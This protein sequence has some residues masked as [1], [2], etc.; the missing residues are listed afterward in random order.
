M[1]NFGLIFIYDNVSIRSINISITLAIIEFQ[2]PV[3]KP[4][5]IPHLIFLLLDSLSACATASRID[6]R[7]VLLVSEVL[8]FSSSKYTSTSRLRNLFITSSMST[9]LRPNR[10]T[11]LVII[12]SIL[13]RLWCEL[14]I[15][16]IRWCKT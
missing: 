11:D 8:M 16:N 13:F 3:S 7:K 2:F 14:K 1:Y 12:K 15:I 9:V 5:R 4:R 10:L 6:N